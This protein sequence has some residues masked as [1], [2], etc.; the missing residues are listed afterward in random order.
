[1]DG[2]VVLD[3]RRHPDRAGRRAPDARPVHPHRGVR[4]PAPHR[5]A[6][7]QADRLPGHL[8]VSQSMHIIGLYVDGKRHV[9]DDSAAD[10]LPRQPGARHPRALQAPPR[11]GLR[12]ALRAGDR[13]PG[14]RP[15]RRGG[16]QRLEMVRRI[17]DEIAG[18]VV[19]LGTDGRLLVPPARRADGR[20]RRRPHP[21]HPRLPADRPRRRTSTRRCSELDPLSPTELLDLSRWPRRSASAR[22][23]RLD[24]AVTPARLPAA[25]QGAAAARPVVDRLVDHFG[26]L[27]SCSAAVEDLQAVEGVGDARARGVREGLSRL[28]ESSI[29]ERYV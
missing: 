2:A 25:R 29:L 10:P 21:G 26:S 7:R 17:A 24:A 6:G 8:G 3:Q 5:R 11:R 20:R 23:E 16:G 28:A 19:E 12:H 18:Y 14:H 15:R 4:H 9:L 27:Q 13:R 1:M 22:A